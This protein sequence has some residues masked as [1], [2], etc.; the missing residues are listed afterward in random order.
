VATDTDKLLAALAAAVSSVSTEKLMV[1]QRQLSAQES[2]ILQE[3]GR[4]CRTEIRWRAGG[5]RAEFRLPDVSRAELLLTAHV[6]LDVGEHFGD[7]NVS[8]LFLELG[9][10]LAGLAEVT[11]NNRSANAALN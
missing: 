5:S 9:K 3:L 4:T 10:L 6:A 1:L 7:V 11:P 8:L 2:P